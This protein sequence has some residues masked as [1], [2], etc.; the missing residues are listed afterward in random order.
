MNAKNQCWEKEITEEYNSGA[1]CPRTTTVIKNCWKNLKADGR[2]VAADERQSR[3]KTELITIE[4]EHN[5]GVEIEVPLECQ[6]NDDTSLNGVW[7]HYTPTQLR[8]PR[9]NILR[10]LPQSSI[11]VGEDGSVS[12]NL[13]EEVQSADIENI[14]DSSLHTL[15]ETLS[16]TAEL[17]PETPVARHNYQTP[18]KRPA[19]K[20][21]TADEIAPKKHKPDKENSTRHQASRRRPIISLAKNDDLM[22]KRVEALAK[23]TSHTEEEHQIV[24][25][26]HREKLRQEK[27]RTRIL[28]FE[29]KVAKRQFRN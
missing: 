17:C 3:V 26:I 28:L 25:D 16:S 11:E 7:S 9:T 5:Y 12:I 19:L 6:F 21:M 22:S 1:L 10:K 27:V 2:K 8:K 24:M 4:E 13:L 15:S 29:L 18:N 23:V 14:A 20:P